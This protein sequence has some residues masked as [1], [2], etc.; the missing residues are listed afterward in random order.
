[1]V[2]LVERVTHAIHERRP[3][4]RK[5]LLELVIRS[6]VDVGRPTFY[7]LLIIICALLP[8]FTLQSSARRAGALAAARVTIGYKSAACAVLVSRPRTERGSNL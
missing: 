5:E 2:V 3:A 6:A 8:V 7:A 4:T 1:V